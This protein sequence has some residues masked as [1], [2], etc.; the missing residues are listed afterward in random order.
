MDRA[1]MNAI[2]EAQGIDPRGMTNADLLATIQGRAVR[3]ANVHRNLGPEAVAAAAA[4]QRQEAE[5][6]AARQRQEAE[7]A[8]A[9]QRQEEAMAAAQDRHRQVIATLPPGYPVPAILQGDCSVCLEPKR[10]LRFSHPTIQADGTAGPIH[11]HTNDEL[12]CVPCLTLHI[13]RQSPDKTSCFTGPRGKIHPGQLGVLL[14]PGCVSGDARQSCQQIYNQVLRYVDEANVVF[15]PSDP[16]DAL[17]LD[18]PTLDAALMAMEINIEGMSVQ[19]K[20]ARVRTDRVRRDQVNPRA[21]AAAN[22]RR[23]AE[24]VR[25][26][27]ERDAIR[28]ALAGPAVIAQ[29]GQL[30]ME[31]FDYNQILENPLSGV[32][33]AGYTKF[34]CPICLVTGLERNDGCVYVPHRCDPRS[35]KN[36][37][38]ALK[39]AGLNELCS[40]CGR[41]SSNH[42]HYEITPP[43]QPRVNL[44]AIFHGPFNP[45]CRPSGGGRREMIARMLGII[46][47]VNGLPDP[48]RKNQAF[49]TGASNAAERAAMDPRML[50]LADQ[51]VRDRRYA[52]APVGKRF[53]PEGGKRRTKRCNK[54]RTK[55]KTYKKKENRRY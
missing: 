41:A 45:E 2:A 14:E 21:A 48:I 31:D 20:I 25:A 11:V 42:T 18:L 28:A 7:A 43:E 29:V 22:A 27:A 36:Q 19:Q 35:I 53:A 26:R 5:A 34:M 38:L 54:R 6:A 46:Q 23:Q 49:I 17:A 30:I 52:I 1:T 33:I 15:P 44:S 47:Y 9:R 13:S 3:R 12:I 4:R 39:Y 24:G 55:T 37:E 16:I 40:T 10:V 51:S 50:A 8:A 32:G